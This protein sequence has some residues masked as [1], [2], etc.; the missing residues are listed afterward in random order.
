MPN[1]NYLTLE[2]TANLIGLAPKTLRNWKYS[3]R[4]KLPPYK[5]IKSGKRELLRFDVSEV[6][7]WL[8]NG[9]QGETL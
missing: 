9:R 4:S 5:V 2:Q 6:E 3:D 1:G 7:R 8:N